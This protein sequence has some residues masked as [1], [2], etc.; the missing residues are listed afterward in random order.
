MVFR[1]VADNF[2][3]VYQYYFRVHIT[4]IIVKQY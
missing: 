2:L 4:I 3:I 1:T